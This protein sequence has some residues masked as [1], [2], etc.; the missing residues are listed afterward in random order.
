ME[1]FQQLET[2]PDSDLIGYIN[3][4]NSQIPKYAAL[5]EMQKRTN[6]RK[7]VDASGPLPESTI[8]DEVME[9]FA[10][11][12]P[13]L[14]GAMAQS[15]GTLPSP[16]NGLGNMAPPSPQMGMPS[17][18]MPMPEMPM[19]MAAGGGL[20]GYATGGRTGY[21]GGGQTDYALPANM[22]IPALA[23]RLGVSMTNA[24]GSPKDPTILQSEIQTA[25]NSANR[26]AVAPTYEP[27]DLS[28]T[29][30]GDLN[31]SP[32]EQIAARNS[33]A[34]PPVTSVGTGDPVDGAQRVIDIMNRPELRSDVNAPEY[35]APAIPQFLLD[36][37]QSGQ[38]INPSQQTLLDTELSAR[39]FYEVSDL[40]RQNEKNTFA[41]ATLAKAFGTSK[42][43]GEAGAML[44]E[45]A[46][47][48]GALKKA[49]RAEQR[50]IE[51]AKRADQLETFGFA[52]AKNKIRS[53]ITDKDNALSI[54]LSN[55]RG[56]IAKQEYDAGIKGIELE[57]KGDELALSTAKSIYHDEVLMKSYLV[58]S[59]GNLVKIINELGKER[60]SLQQKIAAL[61]PAETLRLSEIQTQIQN[62]VNQVVGKSP[63][64]TSGSP[65]PI[66]ASVLFNTVP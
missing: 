37:E 63:D 15:S 29:G 39:N 55:I 66:D 38:V 49:Q 45:G 11:T 10:T 28:N 42:N 57:F 52:D 22:P 6:I 41:L 33:Q 53:A 3:D 20:T 25:F 59:N 60:T 18:E 32:L 35:T 58:Q 46:L 14:Q 7:S 43:L 30:I 26:P 40:D 1:I 62:L 44:G 50:N 4:P 64:S 24:D 31:T 51:G 2:I 47:G 27:I 23:A 17:P 48:L 56:N 9:E 21:V 34:N 16:P 61:S 36:N 13:G 54:S 65:A 12:S 19:Q 8:A 5:D